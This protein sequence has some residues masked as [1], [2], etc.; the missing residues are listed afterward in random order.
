MMRMQTLGQRIRAAREEAGLTQ[1][2]VARSIGVSG[3]TPS[4]WERDSNVPYPR[5]LRALA[6]L[7]QKPA[8]HFQESPVGSP[9]HFTLQDLAR[10]FADALQG[11]TRENHAR[12]DGACRRN[13][14]RRARVAT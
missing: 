10:V 3:Q 4:R 1:E 9:D 2:D 14:D 5:Q 11:S 12:Y 6:E 13:G 7:F 8:D